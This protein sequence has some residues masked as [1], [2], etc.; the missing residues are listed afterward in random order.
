MQNSLLSLLWG[1]EN[2]P[3]SFDVLWDIHYCS[4]NK[5]SP[6]RDQE[7]K[8][9]LLSLRHFKS[10]LLGRIICFSAYTIINDFTYPWALFFWKAAREVAFWTGQIIN[11]MQIDSIK[12]VQCDK[13]VTKMK[14]LKPER[15]KYRMRFLLWKLDSRLRGLQEQI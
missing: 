11:W 13:R 5:A 4:W 1:F 9:F 7:G 8:L 12:C 10:C 2:T 6:H 15:M 14:F 3:C